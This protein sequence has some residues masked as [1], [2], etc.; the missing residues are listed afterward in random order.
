MN[1]FNEVYSEL[2]L[3]DRAKVARELAELRCN[4][5]ISILLALQKRIN[6]LSRNLNLFDSGSALGLEFEHC[7]CIEDGVIRLL[8][9]YVKGASIDNRA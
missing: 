2:L 4:R 7:C 6:L 9:E 5:S 1:N 3:A 8:E